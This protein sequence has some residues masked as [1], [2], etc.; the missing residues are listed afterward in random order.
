M[1][2]EHPTPYSISLLLILRCGVNAY[3]TGFYIKVLAFLRC[4]VGI[5]NKNVPIIVDISAKSWKK[6]RVESSYGR[7]GLICRNQN[8]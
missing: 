8:G 7:I 2:F 3:F 6:S 5:E 1:D 4:C